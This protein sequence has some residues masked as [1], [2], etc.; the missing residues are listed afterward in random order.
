LD[1]GIK[2]DEYI[3]Q[4]LPELAGSHIGE[5]DEYLYSEYTYIQ[6]ILFEFPFQLKSFLKSLFQ[7]KPILISSNSVDKL[8]IVIENYVKDTNLTG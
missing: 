7:L 1:P 5:N 4:E 2:P 3:K 8:R 6:P